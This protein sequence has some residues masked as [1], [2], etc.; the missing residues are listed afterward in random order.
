LVD[1]TTSAFQ[2]CR[3]DPVVAE[4]GTRRFSQAISEGDGI[5]VIVDVIDLAGARSAEA[6]GA[7]GIVLRGV[8][9]G[10]HD[11]TELPILWL[12][13][14]P[15]TDAANA[16]AD[17]C[18]VRAQDEQAAE[19]HRQALNLGL[20][21]VIRVANEEELEEVLDRL[22]PDIVLLAP[23]EENDEWEH[24]FDLL[25]S[26]PAGK[27][28]IA[29]VSSPSREQV[30]ELERAGIDAVIVRARDVAELVGDA[31]PQV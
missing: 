12:A 18:V 19:L 30:V 25:S 3:Y 13:D 9:G 20:D 17:A 6:E 26:V 2:G 11:A 24:T 21:C 16:G 8:L 1:E 10:I 15:P 29:A 14:G 27:L 5:S 7:E 31:P 4:R 22:D 23:E 28:A